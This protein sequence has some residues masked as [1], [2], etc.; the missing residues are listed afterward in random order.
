MILSYR[1]PVVSFYSLCTFSYKVKV[2]DL[3]FLSVT[4]IVGQPRVCMMQMKSLD[5]NWKTQ[6]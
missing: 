2:L 5:L 6:P 4:V 1:H 3:H